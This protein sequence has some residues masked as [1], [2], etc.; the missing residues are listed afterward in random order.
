VHVIEDVV[1][2][3]FEDDVVWEVF[4][5]NGGIGGVVVDVRVTAWVITVAVLAKLLIF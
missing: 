1:H 2:T 5:M 3:H 4:C